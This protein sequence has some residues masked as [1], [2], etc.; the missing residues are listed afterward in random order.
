MVSDW[1][2]SIDMHEDDFKALS[3]DSLVP[4]GQK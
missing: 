3:L 4:E 2:M 1:M